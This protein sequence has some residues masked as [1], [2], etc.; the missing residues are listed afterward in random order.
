[1]NIEKESCWNEED[2]EGEVN[3]S[4]VANIEGYQIAQFL[5]PYYTKLLE[6]MPNY[7]FSWCS[8]FL[9]SIASNKIMHL[10]HSEVFWS[11]NQELVIDETRTYQ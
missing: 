11:S 10:L 2:P 3:W 5:E 7:I 8:F 9:Y 6:H 1:M 4:N